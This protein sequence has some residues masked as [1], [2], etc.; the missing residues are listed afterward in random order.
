MV[1][2]KSNEIVSYSSISIQ[3]LHFLLLNIKRKFLLLLKFSLFMSSDLQ[4]SCKPKIPGAILRLIKPPHSERTISF[5][6]LI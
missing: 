4:T 1:L 3:I 5:G 2:K 6:S